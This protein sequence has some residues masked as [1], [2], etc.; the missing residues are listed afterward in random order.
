MINTT[1]RYPEDRRQAP[2]RKLTLVQH[3]TL[4]SWDVFLSLFN[5]FIGFSPVDIVLLQDPPVCRG[6]TPSFAGFKSFAPPVPKPRVACYVSLSFCKRYTLLPSF[7]PGTEDVMFL[8]VFTPGGCFGSPAPSFRIGNIYSRYLDRPHSFHTV[9]PDVGLEDLEI[10]YLPAGYFNI[11]NPASDPLRI[12][13]ATE[14]RASAP[15]FDR[16]ADLGFALLNTP[17]VY[18]RYP[19]SGDY[20][21]S[22]ID[23]AF[24]NPLMFPAF[25]SWDASSLPSMGSDHVPIV[26]KISPPT[27]SL[28][29]PRPKWD[30]T[31]WASLEDPLK[32]YQVPPA[33]PNPS[34][35]QLDHW[36]SSALGTITTRIKAVTPVSRP[37]PHSKP[38]WTPLLTAL[39]KEYSKAVRTAK[40][41]QS[42]YN[43][44]L[45]KLSRNG[46][47]KAIKRARA[48]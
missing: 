35:R 1:E 4:G 13:S 25:Q 17:G 45:A 5:S 11:H 44:Q 14:E 16:A 2:V 46:Y 42:S 38:W 41:T 40:K 3:N 6:F 47:F 21:P 43:R 19:L 39:R 12:V 26:I 18:T 32:C 8:N 29:P 23:L 9:S 7:P 30:D 24:A 10:P 22:V 31:D 27:N 48:S 28:P 37:S 34:P 15:Y 20:R 33:P 36:F